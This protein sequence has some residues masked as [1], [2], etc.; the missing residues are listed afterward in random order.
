M[1]SLILL[2]SKQCV[3]LPNVKID[4]S[5][6]IVDKNKINNAEMLFCLHICL[7]MFVYLGCTFDEL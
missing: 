7:F 4:S 6:L 3:Q 5:K 2:C 1:T